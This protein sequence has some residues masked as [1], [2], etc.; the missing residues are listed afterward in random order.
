VNTATRLWDNGSSKIRTPAADP[1]TWQ[2]KLQVAIPK[3]STL[4]KHPHLGF[5]GSE[6]S[7]RT[8]AADP[9][10]LNQLALEVDAQCLPSH[11]INGDGPGARGQHFAE[12]AVDFAAEQ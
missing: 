1:K 10:N 6:S 12:P 2:A 4:R 7:K 9:L 5:K 3:F 8:L 11:S